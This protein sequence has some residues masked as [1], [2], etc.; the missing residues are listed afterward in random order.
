MSEDR[1]IKKTKN[2]IKKT[3]I[4]L[5][6]EKSI[7]H[8]SVTELTELADI[9]RK[10]F[11]LHYNSIYEA[12]EDIDNDL[13]TKLNEILSSVVKD[14]HKFNSH[15]LYAFFKQVDLVTRG[16][17]ELIAYFMSNTAHSTLYIKVKQILKNTFLEWVNQTATNSV[18]NDYLAE[19][20]VSGILATYV[21]WNNRNKDIPN[22]ELNEILTK[23]C[24]STMELIK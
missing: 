16:H 13:I 8:I 15:D 24:A 23:L 2:N 14:A 4:E 20:V 3:L 19:F 18:S 11:Y 12:K 10:T 7:N 17:D 5:L 21:Q 9:S 6:K 22:D 1:R